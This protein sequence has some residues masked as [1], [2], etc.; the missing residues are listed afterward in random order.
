[1]KKLS[2]EEIIARGPAPAK[3]E[4]SGNVS[5]LA[6]IALIAIIGGGFA[7]GAIAGAC[8]GVA[9]GM[10]LVG[11]IS[12]LATGAVWGGISG[13]G[14]IGVACGIGALLDGRAEKKER[15]RDEAYKAAMDRK[16]VAEKSSQ[17]NLPEKGAATKAFA[18]QPATAA[19]TNT[20]PKNANTAK[21][22][23]FN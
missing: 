16:R 19:N 4:S 14:V 13:A 21:P 18:K 7:I 23:V 15:A 20:A 11:F 1:M 6:M 8:M 2:D 12:G 5:I 9:G 3:K 10:G 17:T 22:L